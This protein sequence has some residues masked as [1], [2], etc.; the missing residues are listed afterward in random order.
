MNT[1]LFFPFSI[2]FIAT[3]I[4][5]ISAI[6][7]WRQ[8]PTAGAATFSLMMIS[9]FIWLLGYTL[10]FISMKQAVRFMWGNIAYIGIA[11]VPATFF[12]FTLEYTGRSKWL[13][14]KTFA[15]LSIE[16]ILVQ[17]LLWTTFQTK[18]F[19]TDVIYDFSKQLPE[20]T[21]NYGPAFWVHAIYSYILLLAG[22]ILL[23]LKLRTASGLYRK[24]LIIILAAAMIP[25]IT[26]I[27]YLFW[28]DITIVDPTALAFFV[29]GLLWGWAIFGYKLID[30][31]P[32]ARDS[33]V[34][35]M[36]DGMM[37]LDNE[38]RIVDINPAAENILNL[39]LQDVVG[40]LA[41][42]A[43]SPWKD[44]VSQYKEVL[45]TNEEIAVSNGE[46]YFYYDLQITPLLDKRGKQ[47]GR[48]ILLKDISERK[49]TENAYYSLVNQTFQGL[50]ILQD[51][52]IR[53]AN[54]ALSEITNIPLSELIDAPVSTLMHNIHPEDLPTLLNTLADASRIEL[55]FMGFENETRW[56]EFSA[57][58]IE[59]EGT[60]AIQAVINDVTQRK[61]MEEDLRQAR[62]EAEDANRAKSTFLANMSHEIRTPLSAIIGY[63]EMLHEQAQS[64]GDEKLAA[65]LKNI[66]TS[67]YHLLSILNDLLDISRI[68]SGNLELRKEPFAIQSL[69]DTVLITVRSLVTR[70]KNQF[71]VEVADDLGTMVGDAT[72]I[73]QIL[74]N[75]LSNA[76]KFTT[77]GVVTLQVRK[78]TAVSTANSPDILEFKVID[79][80]IGI[81]PELL[82]VIFEPFTQADESLTRQYGGTGLG[83]AI[84]KRISEMMDGTVHV[85]SQPGV[86]STFTVHLPIE[87][88]P[89]LVA[90]I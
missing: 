7:G 43:L 25:W 72:K 12:L 88:A 69:I 36:H 74:T 40:Q 16:P 90:E 34:E 8:R 19:Y 30:V 86:G 24:Q 56:L 71:I 79:T 54:P 31:M 87:P 18:L 66:E 48:L 65:R 61:I 77:N 6:Y 10:E 29:T 49:Q 1:L 62:D 70:N 23:F 22:T 4:S 57:T 13:S 26:N 82:S 64:K 50:V 33:V 45:H 20:A 58:P 27:V 76:G 55:R 68:E 21:F 53:F 3:L 81:A 83:L 73:K 44:I 39:Q 37:V 63:S 85:E 28:G 11:L 80:G 84:T 14:W 60:P 2:L 46:K 51:M 5:F 47:T 67:A 41:Q 52:Y 75:L 15:L 42:E 32:I 9:V 89:K 38:N 78:E 17:I 59:Y 35:H